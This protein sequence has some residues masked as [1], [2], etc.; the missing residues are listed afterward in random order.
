[1]TVMVTWNEPLRLP[2]PPSLERETCIGDAA[3]VASRTLRDSSPGTDTATV[4]L[5]SCDMT[6]SGDVYE[7]VD[8][9]V[10]ERGD[11]LQGGRAQQGGIVLSLL[12]WGTMMHHQITT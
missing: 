2:S 3:V 8:R 10:Q 7:M 1:M 12:M 4:T 9:A 11:V 5:M 6:G